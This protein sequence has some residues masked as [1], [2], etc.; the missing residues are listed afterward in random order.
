MSETAG[1]K[2]GKSTFVYVTYI[3]TTAGRLW[4]ALTD[5][6]TMK[7]YW[8]GAHVEA[9]W[10]PGGAWKLM[11]ADGR[12][13]D[14]G[15]IL[16]L[17][18]GKRMVIRWRNEWRPEL[19]AEGFSRCTIELEPAGDQIKLTIL[20]EIDRGESKFIEAVSNGWP[21]ILSNLKSL[22]ETAQVTPAISGSRG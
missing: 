12:L 7:Q 22:L 5:P 11:M 13:G 17:D 14:S 6:E 10:K 18:P 19:T 20:H 15:Q 21:R 1:N 9:E 3:R 2:T 4:S 8:L 16:E